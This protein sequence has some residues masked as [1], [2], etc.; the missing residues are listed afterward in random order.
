V[1][2]ALAARRIPARGPLKVRIAN[3]NGFAIKGKLSGRTVNRISAT[4]RR[5][6]KLKAR[7]FRVGAR[8]KRT[9]GL[10]LPQ[11]LRRSLR[12]KGR[13]RLRLTAKVTD[14]AGNTRTVRRNVAPRLRRR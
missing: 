12:R 1:T 8:A 10:R 2:L 4:R 14:P 3:A 7:T 5:A 6:V 13:L 11:A 9:V